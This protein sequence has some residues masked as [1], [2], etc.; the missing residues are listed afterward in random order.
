MRYDSGSIAVYVEFLGSPVNRDKFTTLHGQKGVVT[1]LPDEEMPMIR[2][3]H[4]ELVI[5]SSVIIK[6]GTASQLI[7]AACGVY[8]IDLGIK[9][10]RYNTNDLISMYSEDY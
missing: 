9:A 4:A 10:S 7:E 5:G 2:N 8:F 3:K 1:I 6:R